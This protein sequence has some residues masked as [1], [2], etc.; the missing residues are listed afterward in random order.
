M[1]VA[2][3]VMSFR[4]SEWGNCKAFLIFSENNLR[5]QMQN[6]EQRAASLAVDMALKKVQDQ[7]T[8]LAEEKKKQEGLLEEARTL[9][10]KR[11]IF[12]EGMTHVFNV[13]LSDSNFA[14]KSIIEYVRRS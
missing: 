14:H 11:A 13:C 12:V 5:L 8:K 6:P 4:H 9:Q 2:F 10:K 3:K 7:E 1:H